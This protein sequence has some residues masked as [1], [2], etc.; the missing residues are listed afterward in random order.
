[1]KY[2]HIIF[3]YLLFTAFISSCSIG[4]YKG[5]NNLQGVGLFMFIAL[6]I[7]GRRD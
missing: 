4:I 3:W 2:I 5:D 1:M 6:V 7:F